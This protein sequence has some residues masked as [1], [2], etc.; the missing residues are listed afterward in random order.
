MDWLNQNKYTAYPFNG[1]VI[2]SGSKKNAWFVDAGVLFGPLSGWSYNTAISCALSNSAGNLVVV[3]SSGGNTFTFTV[4]SSTVDNTTFWVNEGS[5]ANKG[6]A[7]IT[8]GT[9]DASAF[10]IVGTVTLSTTLMQTRAKSL[11]NRRVTTLSVANK[12][13]A[14]YIDTECSINNGVSPDGYAV[15]GT[16]I[17]GDVKFL[18]GRHIGVTLS[19]AANEVLFSLGDTGNFSATAPCQALRPLP[20]SY[21]ATLEPQCK[22]LLYTFN[23]IGPS[24][25]TG[26]F[27]FDSSQGVLVEAVSGNPN[28][29]K[30]TF[31]PSGIFGE[32][33][34]G[35]ACENPPISS[36]PYDPVS[37]NCQY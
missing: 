1:D 10:S 28:T 20:G 9:L 34:V 30:V 12:F 14:L 11:V 18:S 4:P 36:N 27:N 16:N 23:G 3:L 26:A 2:V 35:P 5:S 6:R 31:V 33:V 19:P 13:A 7:F 15:V 22:D 25:E 21:N 17:T 29:L 8:I 24:A 32:L 37:D